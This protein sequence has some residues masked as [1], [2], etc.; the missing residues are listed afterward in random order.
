M[1]EILVSELKEELFKVTVKSHE[2]EHE[3]NEEAYLEIDNTI[4]IIE[5]TFNIEAMKDSYV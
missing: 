2:E 3:S 4:K 5:D 1:H